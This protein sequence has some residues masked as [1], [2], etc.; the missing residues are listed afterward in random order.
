MDSLRIDMSL[1]ALDEHVRANSTP[2]DTSQL[3]VPQTERDIPHPRHD[4]L[5]HDAREP[6]HDVMVGLVK[7]W[8]DNYHSWH[9]L[10]HQPSLEECLQSQGGREDDTHSL[11][12]KAIAAVVIPSSY[13]NLNLSQADRSSWSKS[14]RSQ[15]LFSA[16]GQVSFHGL[17]AMLILTVLDY[18]NGD[19]SQFWNLIGICQR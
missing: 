5:V 3:S 11:I 14:L 6:S 15:V 7:I 9:P 8:F 18:G 2:R 4:N 17:Q 1:C 13:A 10:L 19:L 12:F 16:I